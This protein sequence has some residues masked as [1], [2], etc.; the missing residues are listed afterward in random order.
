MWMAVAG[1]GGRLC[2][3]IFH[4]ARMNFKL[5]F[6][7][8]GQWAWEQRHILFRQ[9]EFQ[10]AIFIAGPKCVQAT[11]NLFRLA[12]SHAGALGVAAVGRHSR[13]MKLRRP[14]RRICKC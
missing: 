10:I 2:K 1:P 4:F 8:L 9:N 6:P 14:R 12:I 7:S 11:A 3:D 5:Q 13:E